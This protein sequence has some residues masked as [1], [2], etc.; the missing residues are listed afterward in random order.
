MRDGKSVKI[1]CVGRKGF[2][3]LRRDYP[4]RRE[5]AA[6]RFATP[7]PAALMPSLTAMGFHC[8]GE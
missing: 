8:A 4:Q 2:D 3:Q 6:L 7:P 1:L 5:F